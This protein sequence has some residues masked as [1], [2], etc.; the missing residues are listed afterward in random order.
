M[1]QDMGHDAGTAPVSSTEQVSNDDLESLLKTSSQ[2]GVLPGLTVPWVSLQNGLNHEGSPQRKL[3]ILSNR[4]ETMLKG[5]DCTGIASVGSKPPFHRFLTSDSTR[6]VS[7][8]VAQAVIFCGI[9]RVAPSLYNWPRGAK[10]K[11]RRS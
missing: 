5:T 7:Y 4:Q 8:E 9:L 6:P 10:L 2:G 3:Q 1:L 11:I